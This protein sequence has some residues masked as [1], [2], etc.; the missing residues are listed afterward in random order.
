MQADIEKLLIKPREAAQVLSIGLSSLY[1]LIRSG[2][3]PSI[4]VGRAIRIERKQLDEWIRQQ[5]EGGKQ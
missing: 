3:L 5:G 4:R 1:V 2:E